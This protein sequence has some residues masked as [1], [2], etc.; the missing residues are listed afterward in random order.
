MAVSTPAVL[1]SGSRSTASNTDTTASFTPTANALL[2]ALFHAR[3]GSAPA[4]PTITDTATLTW[5]TVFS[6]TFNST[7]RARLAW[8]VAP[9]SPSAMTVTAD[10]GGSTSAGSFGLIELTG[11]DTTT[12]VVTSSN[13]SAGGTSTTPASGTVP[14]MAD[15]GNLQ[16]LFVPHRANSSTPEAASS[17][18]EAFDVGVGGATCSSACYYVQTPGDTS[19]TATM[20]SS[21]PWRAMA[22]EIAVAAAVAGSPWY[23]N[24]QQG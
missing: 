1:D 5:T 3:A 13:V 6:S 16:L 7:N 15:A 2:V 18:A 24:A 10:Y 23:Y 17:W 14:A 19:P 21:A 4:S 12:P 22:I 20:N 9:A 8:A 11:A